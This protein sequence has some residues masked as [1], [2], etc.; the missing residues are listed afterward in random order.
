MST[1]EEK[2]EPSNM[3][4][5]DK[6]EG[7]EIDETGAEIDP[8]TGEVKK[9][10]INID[11]AIVTKYIGL[12]KEQE[13]LE[14]EVSDFVKKNGDEIT[15]LGAQ[16]LEY[17]T[18]NAIPNLTIDGSMVYITSRNIVAFNKDIE[19]NPE[20][21]RAVIKDVFCSKIDSLESE[22]E[23][24]ELLDFLM[25][26]DTKR[27]A[28]EAMKADD[29]LAPLVTENYN[30]NTLT[31]TLHDLNATFGELPKSVKSFFTLGSKEQLKVK[32]NDKSKAMK[33]KKAKKEKK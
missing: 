21:K 24:K 31:A 2:K 23:I 3:T 6:A 18:D 22:D 26:L 10:K 1:P 17:M 8:E 11:M 19:E 7:L 20:V 16:I 15:S 32:E 4:Y 25:G 14:K 29:E 5:C 30:S 13:D 33:A 27:L 28:I 9:K 12:V